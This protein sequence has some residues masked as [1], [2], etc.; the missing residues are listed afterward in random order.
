MQF[1]QV[2]QQ[3]LVRDHA[4]PKLLSR[5]LPAIEHFAK[6]NHAPGSD[7]NQLAWGRKRFQD[8]AYARLRYIH[9]PPSD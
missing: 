6:R 3:R 8:Q 4:N 1:A 2:H 9:Q 7:L 5:F